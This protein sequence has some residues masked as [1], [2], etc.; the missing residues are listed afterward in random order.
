MGHSENTQLVI[1]LN[2][3]F[4]TKIVDSFFVDDFNGGEDKVEK[5]YLLFKKLKLRILS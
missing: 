5:A 3:N 1:I 2:S 4:V